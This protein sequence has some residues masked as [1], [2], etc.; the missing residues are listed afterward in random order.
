MAL[1]GSITSSN[2]ASPTITG[3]LNISSGNVS[4][5]SGLA[6]TLIDGKSVLN[7]SMYMAVSA[8]ESSLS[9]S[10]SGWKN[11]K[12]FTFAGGSNNRK[13]ATVGFTGYITAGSYYWTWRLYN[14]REGAAVPLMAGPQDNFSTSDAG[15][16]NIAAGGGIHFEGNVH[17]YSAQ[18]YKAFD[19]RDGIDGDTIYLQLRGHTTGGGSVAGLVDNSQTLYVKQFIVFHG[20]VTGIPPGSANYYW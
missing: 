9:N 8:G 7:G 18:S 17:Q 3:N 10:A 2:I 19:F 12:S 14:A 16:T 15:V 6:Q 20:F 4:Y 13:V 1:I 11:L 5:N